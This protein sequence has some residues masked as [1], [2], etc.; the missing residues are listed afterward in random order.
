MVLHLVLNN[1]IVILKTSA[2]STPDFTFCAKC[3]CLASLETLGDICNV[4]FAGIIS[5]AARGG[6]EPLHDIRFNIFLI[7]F[8]RVVNVPHNV[9]L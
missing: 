7:N 8:P 6:G 4:V 9:H 5:D 2:G 1:E 3:C